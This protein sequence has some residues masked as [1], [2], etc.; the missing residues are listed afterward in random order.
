MPNN[1]TKKLSRPLILL[2]TLLTVTLANA[3]YMQGIVTEHYSISPRTVHDILPA[4]N[5]R[6]PI[7]EHGMTFHGHTDW[8]ISWNYRVQP[9]AGGCVLTNIQTRIDIKYTLPK[10]D[11]RITDQAII[12]RFNTFNEA[13]V[14]HEHHHG[15]NGLKAANEI[16]LA[17]T[18]LQTPSPDAPGNCRQLDRYA[19]QLG[20]S[21]VQKYATLD[22][23]YDRVTDNGRLE[24]AYIE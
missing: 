9:V 12:S 14:K 15:D 6:S 10:L 3:S 17:L 21:I 18:A 4:L 16:D 8:N 20:H 22:T 2:G 23:E 19:N 24:G 7:R 11:E 5:W 13:L 1:I